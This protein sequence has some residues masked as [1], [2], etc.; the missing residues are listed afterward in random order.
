M[1]QLTHVKRWSLFCVTSQ[2]IG[3]SSVCRLMLLAKSMT[4]EEIARQIIMTLSTELGIPSHLVL[5]TMRDR[6]S[7]NSV[8]MRTVSIVYNRIMDIGCFSRTIDLVREKMKTPVLDDFSKAWIGLFSRSPKTCLLW[9]TRTGLPPPPSFSSTRWWSRFEV[10]QHLHNTFGDV[11]SF[12]ECDDMPPATTTKLLEILRDPSLCRKLKMELSITVNAMEPFVKA[13]YFLEGDSALALLAY[14]RVSAVFSAI[15]TEHY[16]NVIAI[17]K[18]LSGGNS[19]RE[20]QLVSY[21]R[22]CVQPAYSYSQNKFDGELKPALLVFKTA[23]YF[24]LSKLNELKPTAA[25]IDSLRVFTFF[26]STSVIDGLKPELSTYIAATED[27]ST[28]LD[29]TL[30]WKSHADLLPN[31]SQAFKQVLLV[32]PSSAA[33]ERVFSIHSN[34]SKNLH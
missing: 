29:P 19:A 10:I 2:M 11:P 5:A 31:W 14:E 17:A 1:G 9:K 26:D 13:T 16:P 7:V 27:V 20:Q 30:W 4:V 21:A 28:E 18:Q 23:R 3:L 24:T 25:D 6:A 32:Q 15:S 22:S 12:L 8:A 33:S 34:H